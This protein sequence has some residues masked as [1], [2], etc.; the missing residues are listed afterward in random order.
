[1]STPRY[2]TKSRFKLGMD[3]PTKLF[4][5]NKPKVY[6]DQNSD[7]PFLMALA[8]GGF[9]I[10]ELAKCY[11]PGGVEVRADRGGYDG[12]LAATAELL[13]RDKVTIFEA[14]VR[15]ENFFIRV[16]I[17]IKNGPHLEVVEVKSKSYKDGETEFFGRRGG[18]SSEWETYLYDVAFQKFVVQNAFPDA[19]VSAF[20][21]LADKGAAC[22]SDGLNQKFRVKTGPNDQKFCEVI[23]PLAPEEIDPSGW[24]L[25]K[26]CVDD[27]CQQIFAGTDKKPPREKS[28]AELAQE[29]A[30]YYE[31]DQRVST[32]ITGNCKKCEYRTTD[33]DEA[34][35]L[36]SGYKECWTAE[37]RWAAEDFHAPTVLD[38]WDNR[39]K[40]KMISMGKIKFVDLEVTD[41]GVKPSEKPGMSRTERQWLQV[42]KAVSGDNQC[43]LDAEGL[44]AEMASWRFPLHFIDFETATPGIPFTK[45]R[46][47]Y[48]QIA[49][50]FSHHVVHEDGRVEH[51]G[52]YLDDRIAVFPNFDFVRALKE[53]L[54]RDD[55]TIFRY[56]AHENSY[57][58]AIHRQLIEHGEAV[59]DRDELCDFIR[60]ITTGSKKT[61]GDDA[62]EGERTMVDLCDLVKRYYYDPLTKGSNSIKQVLPAILNSS[63]YLKDKYSRP[64]Y[65][66][67]MSSRNFNGQ[68]W[69][70]FDGEKV[71]DP[72]TLLPPV[73]GSDWLGRLGDEDDELKDGGAAMIAYARLQFEDMPDEERH[74]IKAALKRYCELDTL[75]MV[76]I[77]EGWRAML[78][79][80]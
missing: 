21:M 47:P 59:S 37:L 2:L 22:P 36:S 56:A 48:E 35:G 79:R 15:F 27:V 25:K 31:R 28:F 13:R 68:V 55:G 24:I 76:M 46:R 26:V 73:F 11:F 72:Y 63:D 32:P 58:V 65:G 61:F 74:A 19:S 3:C 80:A 41:I 78:R 9:Q 43:H 70:E 38:I 53:Q 66:T 44:R 10:G 5:T 16:D 33:K 75:A 54:C 60:S 39:S 4:Y 20:L 29:L 18:I 42:C 71:R 57:L 17:L 67:E 30:G 64:I 7:D 45:G 14:A 77:Y 40:D 8:K 69:V 23:G 34:E 51:A 1:M 52:E 49:F 62:W 50:Q 6:A 12:A